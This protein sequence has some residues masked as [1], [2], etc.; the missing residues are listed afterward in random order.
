MAT[1]IL[2]PK[3][4]NTV[5]TCL[6]L[7][8][9]KKKGDEIKKGEVICE[10]E[11][12]KAVFEIESPEAGIILET[13]FEEG[14]DVPVL[15]NIAVVGSIGEDFDEYSP[16]QNKS[17]VE[18]DNS[19]EEVISQESIAGENLNSLSEEVNETTISKKKI[20]PR[21]KKLAAKLKVPFEKLEGTGP[22]DRII[23][24]DV[25]KAGKNYKNLTSNDGNLVNN[26]DSYPSVENVE[27]KSDIESSIKP[28][29]FNL[30]EENIKVVPLR[31][32]RKIIAERML[33]SLKNSA[34]LTLNSSAD[35]RALLNLRK[36][37]KSSIM[38]DDFQ[39]V[40][41]NDLIHFAVVKTLPDHP[42]L[43]SLLIGD[44]IEYYNRIHLGFAVDTPR[45]LMV[46]VIRNSHDMNL[47]QLSREAKRLAS[48]SI[49]GKIEPEDL[50]GATFTVT[51]LGS[52][53]IES[54]SPVLNLPQTGIL[55]VNAIS[56]KP[57]E[58][59]NK[60]EFIHYVYFSLTIDHRAIDGAA[61]ARFLQSLAK[62]INEIDLVITADTME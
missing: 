56:L 32:I 43:N 18:N 13:F 61:G 14:D 54:F 55:G 39:D 2:L 16:M 46:P 23:E 53:G 48:A 19:K 49:S 9:R 25:L 34:Q 59:D 41:I 30:E 44:S 6:I 42:E 38:Y 7:E 3:Q 8:W 57:I 28:E 33:E 11:T 21:A 62:T 45:G 40:T 58:I 22:D 15:T 50:N 20:S 51:N 47:L 24:R 26:I 1:P 27:K 4:G 36:R 31:G 17:S 52:Y 37:F 29:V 10:I 12:D 35:A 60:I 5:E